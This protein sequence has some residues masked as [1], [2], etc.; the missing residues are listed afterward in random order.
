MREIDVPSGTRW[1]CQR[2]GRRCGDTKYH[3][4]RLTAREAKRISILTGLEMRTF[5]RRTYNKPYEYEI[6]KI[7]SKCILQDLSRKASCM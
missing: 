7:N 1:K 4:R 6:R 2:C 3:V 5:L